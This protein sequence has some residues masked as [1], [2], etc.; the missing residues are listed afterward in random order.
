MF[1]IVSTGGHTAYN[2]QHFVVD[3]ETDLADLP[4]DIHAGSTAFIIETS[5]YYMLNNKHEW[6]TVQL[7]SGTPTGTTVIYEGGELS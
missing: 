7:G 5:K 6:V 3:T 4:I 1:S 2:L